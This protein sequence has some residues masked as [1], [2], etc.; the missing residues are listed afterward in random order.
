MVLHVSTQK[1]L[2][3]KVKSHAD[4]RKYFHSIQFKEKVI[5][6]ENQKKNTDDNLFCTNFTEMDITLIQRYCY[7]YSWECLVSIVFT[8]ATQRSDC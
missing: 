5:Q 1:I 2:V 7:P 4:G 8:W 3:S 6:L